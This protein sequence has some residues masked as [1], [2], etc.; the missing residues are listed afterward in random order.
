MYDGAKEKIVAFYQAKSECAK[1]II[2]G[3]KE[4]LPKYMHPNIL[5]HYEKLPMN[6]NA[7]IDRTKLKEEYTHA[8]G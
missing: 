6:K 1:E 3:L 2:I 5:I 8:K 4:Y 7:K